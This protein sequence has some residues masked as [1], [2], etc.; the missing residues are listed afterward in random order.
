MKKFLVT[1][2][3]ALLVFSLCACNAPERP[4]ETAETTTESDLAYITEK[5][6]LVIGITDYEPMNF[7]D[8]SGEWT[9]FDTEFA[10]LVGEK[11]GVDVEFIEID[12]DNKQNE[13]NSKSVDCIWNGMTLTDEVMSSMETTKPYVINAQVVVMNADKV[14]E[15]ADVDSL[16]DL[17]FS[18]EA[19]SAGEEALTENGIENFTAVN[20]QADAL[21][22]VASG[23]A[24]ACVID[25]TMANAMTGEGTSYEKLTAG[26]PLTEEEYGIGFRKGSDA[27]KGVD[28]IIDELK[29]DGSLEELAEKYELTLAD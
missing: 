16:K 5:G 18:V 8:E 9:G 6:T 19:G 14:S 2:L 3:A 7:K 22:E 21:M 15:Y 11:L 24:D 27:A 12:W 26:L 1:L 25:I 17:K 13:L 23:S 29:A 4:T 20:T 10:Y 28:E